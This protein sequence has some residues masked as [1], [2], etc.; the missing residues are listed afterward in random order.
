[1]AVQ[2]EIQAAINQIANRR[3]ISV[4]S[5][6]DS[7]ADS[8]KT[9]INRQYDADVNIEVEIDED[10]DL[11]AYVDKEVVKKVKNEVVEISTEEAKRIA[12]DVE[13]G[14][15]VSV[16]VS[17][18]QFG[19]I[20]AQAA[21]NA[22]ISNVSTA[23]RNAILDKIRAMEGEISSAKVR[24]MRGKVAIVEVE[25]GMARLP[26]E[27]QIPNEYYKIN[28]TYRV[29]IVGVEEVNGRDEIIVSRSRPEFLAKLFE[30][31]V[32]EI[33]SDTVEVKAVARE[34]GSRSKVAVHTDQEG[35]DPVGSCIGQQGAR[36]NAIMNELGGE[37]VDVILWHED[38]DKFIE[39]A[40]SPAEVKSVTYDE[41]EGEALVKVADDQLSLTIG[42]GGQNVRLAAHL[43]DAKI[44]VQSPSLEG[45]GIA[46]DEDVDEIYEQTSKVREK[47]EKDS[48]E[49]EDTDSAD[50]EKGS[51][52]EEDAEEADSEK[53]SDTEKDTEKVDSDA[54]KLEE[55]TDTNSEEDQVADNE[56]NEEVADK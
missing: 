19:R 53:D 36:I 46:D 20:A 32:P 47:M 24:R 27:E 13:E 38:K 56:D 45:E 11:V 35:I 17:F 48:S 40:L 21:K 3:N 14:D 2:S 12:P 28:E 22:L 37:K 8:I 30:L 50:S 31:E 4:E 5:I 15:T 51:N 6:L 52:V 33:S 18:N 39:N 25:G 54:E 44:T 9:A 26:E 55:E 49:S 29:V 16:E 10:G 41:K 34:V 7:I 1:M 23:E 43:T 42:R